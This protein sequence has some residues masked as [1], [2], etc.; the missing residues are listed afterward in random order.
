[1]GQRLDALRRY[2]R[3]HNLQGANEA[4]LSHIGEIS[5]LDLTDG[6]DLEL[7]SFFIESVLPLTIH[8]HPSLLINN[9]ELSTRYE[10]IL[11]EAQTL[12]YAREALKKHKL[13]LRCL[14]AIAS[15]MRG[16]REQVLLAAE[17]NGFEALH[18]RDD[19][20]PQGASFDE[21]ERF[22][23]GY[24][25]KARKREYAGPLGEISAVVFDLLSRL[26]REETVPGITRGLFVDGLTGRG[27]VRRVLARV[28]L[29]E[30]SIAYATL[31]KEE[32]SDSLKAASQNAWVASNSYLLSSGYVEG[33]KERK[34]T[35]QITDLEVRAENLRTFYDG[36]SMGFPLAMAIISAYLRQP[37]AS[38]VAFTGAFDITSARDGRLVKVGG[39]P[40]KCRAAI[41]KGFRFIFL[42]KGNDLD[43]DLSLQKEAERE[44]FDISDVSSISDACREI[45][46]DSRKKSRS[47][48]AKEA[49]LDLWGILTFKPRKPFLE[50]NL[51][52]IWSSSLLLVLMYLTEGLLVYK[53]SSTVP[54]PGSIFFLV[55]VPACLTMFMAIML[56]YGLVP[57]YLEQ[58]RQ[59]SWYAS[60]LL[61]SAAS[62]ITYCLFLLMVRGATPD[63]SRFPDWPAAVG[64][65]KDLIIFL[66]FAVLY[67]TNF[68]NYIATLDFLSRRFQVVTVQNCLRRSNVIDTEV[69]VKLLGISFHWALI[70]AL[71][72]GTLLMT[73]E[74]ITYWTL[75]EGL[76]ASKWYISLG[77]LRD[78]I[79]I[80]LAVEVLLWYRNSIAAITRQVSQV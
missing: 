42:P 30:G 21:V 2:V 57:L 5:L 77:I 1:L 65:L 22:F 61:L 9:P 71:A 63:L 51:G 64:I 10:R 59:D 50:Q 76:E 23:R 44:G 33:L 74:M 41:E 24:F 3:S 78:M 25:E 55:T 67:V 31:G 13:S 52:H 80:L 38:S 34:V 75:R 39:V 37:V 8:D 7:V 20:P 14:R 43:I 26:K 46:G 6:A 62:L 29:G 32:I 35:W 28:D 36:A 18:L 58:Q 19:L 45:F 69:P 49:L 27:E 15:L 16:E 48:M 12:G 11:K 79:F 72:T 56:S 40:R 54:V 66:G 73:F 70:G 47:E 60:S 4:F 53:V 68:F 17:E